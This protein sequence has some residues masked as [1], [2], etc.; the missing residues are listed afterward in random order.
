[1]TDGRKNNGGHSTKAKSQNDKRLNP[2]KKLLSKYITEKLDFDKL[3]ALM[4]K[5]YDDG[6]K[7]NTKSSSLF[8]SYVLGKPKETVDITTDDKPLNRFDLDKLTDSQLEALLVLHGRNSTN[9]K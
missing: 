9:T 7:G 1:M 5:L 6:L 3:D 2:A 8:L 4:T